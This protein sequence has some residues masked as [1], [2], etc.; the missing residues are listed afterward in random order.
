[1]RS[2]DSF[3]RSECDLSF[4]SP[5][6]MK[7]QTFFPLL[8][9]GLITAKEDAPRPHDFVPEEERAED[10]FESVSD[11]S[12]TVTSQSLSSKCVCRVPNNHHLS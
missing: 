6:E 2:G 8:K 1:M 11:H 10:Q 5:V 7:S 3:G 4:S 12:V 9:R